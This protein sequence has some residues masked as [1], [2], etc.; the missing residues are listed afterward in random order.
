MFYVYVL[1]SLKDHQF[2]T[3]MTADL[4]RRVSEHENGRSEATRLR[5]PFRLMYYEAYV[6]EQ[7]AQRR[8]RYLKSGM[9]KRDLR[10]RLCETLN[11]LACGARV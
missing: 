6:N 5:R 1:R 11:A 3:G 2:Y 9:G 7:D 8:E 10:R 4:K